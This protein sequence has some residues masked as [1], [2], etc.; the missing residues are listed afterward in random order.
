MV[1]LRTIYL[2]LISGVGMG[3]DFI[4]VTFCLFIGVLFSD[5]LV[6]PVVP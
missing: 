3:R 4:E 5:N 6:V 1:V 2:I